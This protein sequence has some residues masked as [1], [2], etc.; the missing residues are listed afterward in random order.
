MESKI[1]RNP[2]MRS[3]VKSPMNESNRLF[4][5]LWVKTM[6]ASS[7]SDQICQLYTRFGCEVTWG[8]TTCAK[9]V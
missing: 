5:E 8:C 1:A 6:G 4:D 7:R 9:E 2:A 3:E